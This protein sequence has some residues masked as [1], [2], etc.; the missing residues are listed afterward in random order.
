MRRVVENKIRGFKALLNLLTNVR[1]IEFFRYIFVSGLALIVDYGFYLSILALDTDNPPMIAAISYL[2]GLL[3]AYLLSIN[4]VFKNGWLRKRRWIEF[5]LFLISGLVGATISFI[6]VEIY[7]VKFGKDL[8]AA[9]TIA[10]IL[11]FIV[12]YLIRK[13]IIFRVMS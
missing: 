6:S 1:G 7:L 12:V 8:I 10:V 13:K 9:K 2:T 5:T 4:K 3:V 11:S